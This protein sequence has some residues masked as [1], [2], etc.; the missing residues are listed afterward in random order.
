MS[1]DATPEYDYEE[2]GLVAG[3]EIHQQ[4]DTETKLFCDSPT[5]ERDPDEAD[6][7]ITRQ[8]HPTKSELGELDDAAME[9]SRVDREFTYLAYDTTCLVEED[10]EPPRRVDGEAL[11]VA[12]Q[13]ADLLDLSVVDQA[14]VMRKLVIDGSNT[15][16]F[17]R[18]I[19]LGQDGE[20]ET[21]SGSVSVVDLMLEEESAKRVEETDDGVVY[22]LDR[23]GVPLVEI[24]T[25][26]DIRS[27]EGARQAA[28]RI[29]M[30]LRSTGAVKRGL[31]TIRQDVNVSIA[32]GARVE[33]KGV[34]DLQGIE[35][36]VRGEVGRQAELLEIRDELRERDA[37]V[38]DVSDV[39][40]VFADTESGVIRGA[41][42]AGGKVTAVPLFGF[43]GLVGREIQPDRRLGTELSDH[44]KRHGAGGIF[45]TDEL[46]AYGVTEAEVDALRDAVG[47]GEGDAV[48]IVAAD[49]ETA[50]LAIEA[51][52]DRAETA[53]EGVPEETRGANDDGT[54]RYLR[55]LPGAA[56]MYPETD[57][58]PV[59]PDP[60]DVETPELLDEK[61]ER[62]EAEFGLDAGL[63]EQVAFGQR[64]PLFEAAVERGAEPTFA[65]ST[66][67]STTTEIRRDGAPVENLTD[68][69]FLALFDLVEGG[70]LAKEGVPEVL[71]TLA[72]DPDLTAS[73]A[74]EEAGLSGVSEA[75]VREAVVEVVERNADQVEAEG[76]G[77]FSG[78]MG[79][80]MGALR[81]K[82]DGEVVSDVLREEIGKRS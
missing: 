51:A 65:A 75:E 56:R 41:L 52:A 5:V 64:F 55:P 33:V 22:S 11:S 36:I 15:S 24:G 81:G 39:T 25:G 17:Q 44:A 19:L 72:E 4:L 27:P 47:A 69:H 50:D 66:L 10:D 74:V 26:P 49:P 57:V 40:D 12:L 35:D 13:I 79:E 31:G 9:E 76:M 60:S 16:G 77:A 78:L 53:I 59:E 54:T 73:E 62:Y 7:S 14:H 43:D 29:G 82:A 38:G 37:S 30:L 28:E 23:L 18:S 67:E 61:A 46:P 63:A 20:I 34:Q 45:H 68:D 8:L 1:T 80:A 21:E 58:P 70:D 32:D 2:L 42:D 48:A 6:R 3:L 71:T